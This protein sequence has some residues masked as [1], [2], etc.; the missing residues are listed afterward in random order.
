V[1]RVVGLPRLLL[2][3]TRHRAGLRGLPRGPCR[4]RSSDRRQA[5][6]SLAPLRSALSALGSPPPLMGFVHLRPSADAHIRCPL[7]V[8]RRL[9]SAEQCQLPGP[10]PPPRFLTA[11]TACSTWVLRACCIPLPAMRFAVFPSRAARCTRRWPCAARVFPT[12]RLI[13][14]EEFPSPAAVPRHRGRCPLVVSTRSTPRYYAQFLPPGFHRRDGF[15]RSS[16]CV[17]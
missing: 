13:P 6:C 10:V 8:A 3:L 2:D 4:F 1:Y 17:G 11:L 5:P 14:F 12:T 15:S 16:A 9:P 7:P